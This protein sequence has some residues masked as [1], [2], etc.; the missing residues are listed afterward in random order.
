[1][2][3][4]LSLGCL[5]CCVLHVSAA[6]Y[7]IL[8]NDSKYFAGSLNPTPLDPSFQEYAC[9]SVPLSSGDYCLL[10][11]Q[12]NEASWTVVLDP[13]STTNISLS[14]G[15]YLCSA[16]GCYDFYIK[17][18]YEQ[19][20]LYVGNSSSGDCTDWSTTIGQGSDDTTPTDYATAV[21]AQCEDVILQGFYW[22]SYE[23]NGK[24]GS[25]KW[26]DLSSQ[27][28]EIA[29]SFTM[30]WLPPSASATT[31]N[32]SM[33]YIPNNYGSQASAWG[34]SS[35]LTSLITSFHNRRV[36]VLADI[37]INHGGNKSNSCD[38][39]SMSFGSFGTF[40][41]TKD[42]ITSDDEGGCGSSGNADDGQNGTDKNYAAA[43][44]W[45]HANSQVQ[46]MFKAYLKWMKT[47]MGYDGW[48]YDYVGGFHLKH[49]N[50]YNNA[51]K[52]YF[53]VGEYWYGDPQTL[54]TRVD[55][56]SQ[57]T[58][59]FD[60]AA[61]YTAF[62]DGIGAANYSKLKSAGLRGKGYGKYA[63]LFVDN[64]D[65]F[66][67]S[68][69][70]VTDF[71]GKGDGSSIN[72]ASKVLQANAYMLAMPSVP[73]VFYPH[74]VKYKDEIKKMILARRSAGI[75]SESA[76]SENA[77][78]G[79][80]EATVTGKRGMLILYLGSSATK[81]A[82]AGYTKACAG[83]GYAVY[84]TGTLPSDHSAVETTTV[85]PVAN[86]VIENGQLLIKCGEQTFNAMGQ[87]ID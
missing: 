9:V 51:S 11:D 34:K 54:K 41:P 30:I 36:K 85:T 14:N 43:R 47:E 6:S 40:N 60:F 38:F 53:S 23:T 1:M 16:T 57:N 10:Y 25:T 18:K 58:L 37:V 3:N 35:A 76:I 73:C 50:D 56:A 15:K 32:N 48:R 4:L 45:D 83:S 81:S 20:Q 79:F 84:Y 66:N 49:I 8:V 19:D 29:N 67:R 75:H 70:N 31:F 22:R 62:R 42:W 46:N 77:G 68:D 72:D 69:N 71:L 86:K 26:A 78:S 5:I 17:L 55:D 63:V 82:P 65:T 7:G 21:P 52:P 12:E 87:R 80:Y 39:N 74:W 24:F 64:H 61:Y 27:V 2:K 33:G 28:S 59:L 13:A 44:D